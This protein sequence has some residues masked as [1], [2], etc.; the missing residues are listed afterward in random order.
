MKVNFILISG[1]VN[2]VQQ[3]KLNR[4]AEFPPEEKCFVG[5]ALSA[6]SNLKRPLSSNIDKT[7][8]EYLS[9][10]TLDGKLLY[11]DTRLVLPVCEQLSYK[12]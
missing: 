2:D 4:E 11:V 3:L 9:R 10:H 7:G 6:R 8:K 1:T 12:V 5:V